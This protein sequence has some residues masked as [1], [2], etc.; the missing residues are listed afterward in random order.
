KIY[1]KLMFFGFIEM[2]LFVVIL[3]TGLVYVWKKGALPWE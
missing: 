2:L 3:L 1:D